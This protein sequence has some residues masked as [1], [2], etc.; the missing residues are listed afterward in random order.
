LCTKIFGDSEQLQR[1]GEEPNNC[2]HCPQRPKSFFWSGVLPIHSRFHTRENPFATLF[3]K[4]F[5]NSG[6]AA[7]CESMQLK[8]LQLL[9]VYK[10]VYLIKFIAGTFK[11][12]DC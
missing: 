6:N 5:A 10:V 11:S 3:S 1:H 2:K 7:I 12:F 4:L 8:T 9:F